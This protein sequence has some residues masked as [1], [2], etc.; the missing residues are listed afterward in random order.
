M[1]FRLPVLGEGIESATVTE[2][3]VKP[4][5][6]VQPGQPVVAIETEKAGVEV[7]A[8]TAGTVEKVHVKPGDKIPVGAVIL[9]LKEA[10]AAAAPAQKSEVRE[11]KSE[12]RSQKT[13]V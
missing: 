6:A 10:E 7:P 8:E 11:Q 1:D 5:D 4:G 3:R 12:D 9:T 13:E 2:V